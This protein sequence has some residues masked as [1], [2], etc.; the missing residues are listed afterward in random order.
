MDFQP[1]DSTCTCVTCT[2]YTR[3][4]LHAIINKDPVSCSLLTL[5]NLTYHVCTFLILI[6]LF[7]YLLSVAVADASYSKEYHCW[8][9]S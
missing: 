1:I 7:L 5:H 6:L 3:A 2:H 8:S 9:F 4:A